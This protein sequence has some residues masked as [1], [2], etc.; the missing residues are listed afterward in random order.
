MMKR[1]Q[2]GT[3]KYQQSAF[4]DSAGAAIAIW[5]DYRTLSLEHQRAANNL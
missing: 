3:K 4:V 5:H 2:L 1:W